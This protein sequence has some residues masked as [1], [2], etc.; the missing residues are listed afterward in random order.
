[1]LLGCG[2]FSSRRAAESRLFISRV[3]P[4]SVPLRGPSEE[5]PLVGCPAPAPWKKPS[6]HE[7]AHRCAKSLHQCAPV[8]RFAYRYAKSAHRCAESADQ[9][10]LA[11]ATKHDKN[12]DFWTSLSTYLSLS[13]LYL[14]LLSRERHKRS[15]RSKCRAGRPD[16]HFARAERE[17]Q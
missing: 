1:M 16:R 12:W 4:E 17:S 13:R 2:F 8:R 7:S 6:A 10:G 11:A 5:R 3:S 9:Q 15:Q 14:E